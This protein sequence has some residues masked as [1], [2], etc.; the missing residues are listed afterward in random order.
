MARGVEVLQ[1]AVEGKR[2]RPADA[3]WTFPGERWLMLDSKQ[4]WFWDEN[5]TPVGFSVN[6]V[7]TQGWEVE[8]PPMTFAQAVAAM[9][10]GQIVSRQE[11]RYRKHPTKSN[12]Y[13]LGLEGWEMGDAPGTT[14]WVWSPSGSPDA[15]V[16]FSGEDLH[17]TD[18]RIVR[19]PEKETRLPSQSEAIS[20]LTS[21]PILSNGYGSIGLRPARDIIKGL[22]KEYPAM[23]RKEDEKT[24]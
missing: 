6:S 9:D 21:S 22:A 15:E 11:R 2:I 5:H 23:F 18:W 8:E 19:E 17:A 20:T 4:R 14:K 12:A 24:S 10:A 13:Q 1:A 16:Y 3:R 7:F